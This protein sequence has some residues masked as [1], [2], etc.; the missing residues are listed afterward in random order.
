[1]AEEKPRRFGDYVLKHMLGHGGMG[2]VYLAEDEVNHR[3]VALKV[4]PPALGQRPR[5]H[6][7]LQ[8]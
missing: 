8:A 4:L 1:M 3:D 2:V 5:A 7:P 6:G